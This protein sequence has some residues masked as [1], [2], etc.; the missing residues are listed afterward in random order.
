MRLS[1]LY[2]NKKLAVWVSPKN[3]KSHILKGHI[4]KT[5]GDGDFLANVFN[6]IKDKNS[7]LERLF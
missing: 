2:K 3:Q 7:L 4:S 1:E 5:G 6:S